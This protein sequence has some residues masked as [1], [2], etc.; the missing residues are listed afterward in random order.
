MYIAGIWKCC[1][2]LIDLPAVHCLSTAIWQQALPIFCDGCS[3]GSI[4]FAASMGE[5]E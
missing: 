2:I 1:A 4:L 5:Q 3:D